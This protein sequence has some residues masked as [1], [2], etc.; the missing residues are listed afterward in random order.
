MTTS[1]A[2][3]EA[4]DHDINSIDEAMQ[5]SNK[6]QKLDKTVRC[7]KSINSTLDAAKLGEEAGDAIVKHEEI[8]K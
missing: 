7:T 2:A 8:R 6:T 4:A 3:K 1:E 5:P